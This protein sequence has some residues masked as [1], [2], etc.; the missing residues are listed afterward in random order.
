[1][2]FMWT[3]PFSWILH[4]FPGSFEASGEEFSLVALVSLMIFG[5]AEQLT[6][7]LDLW[8]PTSKVEVLMGN[9]A[10]YVLPAEALLGP[11]V[12][13]SYRFTVNRGITS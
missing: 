5:A 11:I 13:Y 4:I 2:A 3:I 6:N 8:R 10:C 12:L 9:V 1:M 7:P